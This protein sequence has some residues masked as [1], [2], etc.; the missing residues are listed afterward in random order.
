[1]HALCNQF[2]LHFLLEMPPLKS[3]KDAYVKAIVH[4]TLHGVE[5]L[6]YLEHHITNNISLHE[7]LHFVLSDILQP[8]KIIGRPCNYRNWPNV[9]SIPQLRHRSSDRRC[10]TS[11]DISGQQSRLR[12]HHHPL[13][14]EEPFRARVPRSKRRRRR[15]QARKPQKLY[16]GMINSFSNG[17]CKVNTSKLN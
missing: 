10:P 2:F 7:S 9:S 6:L 12:C 16:S 14:A 13:P 8:K 4:Q 11:R 5:R 1:M 17:S 15:N 3:V